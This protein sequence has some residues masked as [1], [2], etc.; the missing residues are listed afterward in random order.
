MPRWCW[1][2]QAACCGWSVGVA[3]GRQ[4]TVQRRQASPKRASGRCR[5]CC[6]LARQPV[7][8]SSVSYV[9]SVGNTYMSID[10]SGAATCAT[11]PAPTDN[12]LAT[13]RGVNEVVASVEQFVERLCLIEA[14]PRRT[15]TA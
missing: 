13:V 3:K 10:G 2:R 12:D 15:G 1:L 7:R 6:L 8:Y 14:G 4:R 11:W 9:R 5:R